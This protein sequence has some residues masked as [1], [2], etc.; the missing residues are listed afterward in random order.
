MFDG[1][2]VV[3]LSDSVADLKHFLRALIAKTHRNVYNRPDTKIH[4]FKQLSSLVRLA[5][6]YQIHDVQDQALTALQTHFASTFSSWD[7]IA[8]IEGDVRWGIEVIHLARLT[9]TPAM[10]P[11]AFYECAQAG[12][13]IVEGWR[14][15]DGTVEYLSPDDLRRM[16]DGHAALWRRFEPTLDR[17]FETRSSPE[18]ASSITC[19]L[20]LGAMSADRGEAE[21]GLNRPALLHCWANIIDEWSETYGFC[22]ACSDMLLKKMNVE[23]YKLW[24]E[25]PRLFGLSIDG[26]GSSP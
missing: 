11:I 7:S 21:N 18:C 22:E 5:H 10:L 26:W 16:I 13:S 9:D 4:T 1:C 12:G 19:N 15:E 20:R 23:R 14:R 24:R 2:P 17:V 3:H 25:L 8:V 6:K